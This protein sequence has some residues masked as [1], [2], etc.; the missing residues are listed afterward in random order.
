MK[1]FLILTNPAII[2][3]ALTNTSCSVV[4]TVQVHVELSGFVPRGH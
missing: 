3:E 2:E 1:S 4:T